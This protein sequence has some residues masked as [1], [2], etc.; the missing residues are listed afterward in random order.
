MIT[1]KEA[2]QQVLNNINCENEL[3]EIECDIK[4]AISCGKLQSTTLL[5]KISDGKVVKIKSNLKK[6]GYR[7]FYFTSTYHSCYFQVSW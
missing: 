7:V 3:Y 2:R 4:R 1:A 5:P 6:R